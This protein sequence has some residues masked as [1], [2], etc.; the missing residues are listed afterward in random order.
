[1]QT[2]PLCGPMQ[3]SPL[4]ATPNN[5]VVCVCEG[6]LEIAGQACNLTHPDERMS[7]LLLC[8]GKSNQGLCSNT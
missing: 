6:K 3:V 8:D 2:R 7:F 5:R 1:L 4:E